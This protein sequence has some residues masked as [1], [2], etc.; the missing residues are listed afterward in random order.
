MTTAT[1]KRIE[2]FTCAPE[3]LNIIE[4]DGRTVIENASVIKMGATLDGRGIEGEINREFLDS[5]FEMAQE[6]EKKR[7]GVNSYVDHWGSVKDYLGVFKNLKKTENE[8]KIV[9]DLQIDNDADAMSGNAGKTLA[10]IA[11][12]N[13]FAFGFSIKFYALYNEQWEIVG[14]EKLLSI[15]AVREANANDGVFS[16]APQSHQSQQEETNMGEKTNPEPL[17]TEKI[18]QAGYDAGFEAGKAKAREELSAQLKALKEAVPDNPEI[19]LASF[20]GNESPDAAK[21]RA[22][23]AALKADNEKLAKELEGLK[24]GGKKGAP[25][26]PPAPV[27]G[28]GASDPA[29]FETVHA[30]VE[31]YMAS[32][33]LSRMDAAK[34]VRKDHPELI[35]N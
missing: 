16:A 6:L 18:R 30:A 27:N 1:E 23:F 7:G 2:S 12:T 33:K 29:E 19:V 14:I 20:E 25:A 31:H 4:R 35:R 26:T 22:E 9:G 10:R 8:T 21:Q 11:K 24:A 32:E 13:P 15:D 28:D 17:D 5:V 3:G 34:K